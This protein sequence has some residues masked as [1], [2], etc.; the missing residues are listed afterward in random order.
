APAIAERWRSLLHDRDRLLG[1]EASDRIALECEPQGAAALWR[2]RLGRRGAELGTGDS[3]DGDTAGPENVATCHGGRALVHGR[4][5]L[6]AKFTPDSR[7]LDGPIRGSRR[8]RTQSHEMST[9]S[10]RAKRT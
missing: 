5:L 1:I 10:S 8:L 3:H 2:L 9:T 7:L 6:A 4:L